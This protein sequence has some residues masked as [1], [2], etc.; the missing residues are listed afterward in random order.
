[1]EERQL[2]MKITTKGSIILRGFFR[3]FYHETA[4]LKGWDTP[5]KDT[6]SAHEQV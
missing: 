5:L 4:M 3:N 2:K 6:T 1:M